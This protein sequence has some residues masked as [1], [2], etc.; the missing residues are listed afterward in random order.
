MEQQHGRAVPGTRLYDEKLDVA[1]VDERCF[2]VDT[3]IAFRCRHCVAR[4][5]PTREL[6][7]RQEPCEEE[8][9][10]T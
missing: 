2:E 1:N 10:R 7:R 3:E 8:G 9:D 5:L 6:E 4:G